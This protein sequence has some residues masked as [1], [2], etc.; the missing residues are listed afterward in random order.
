MAPYG[1]AII[2][3]IIGINEADGSSPQA[4]IKARKTTL[5]AVQKM[6]NP[7]APAIDQPNPR[8]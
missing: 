8:L 4:R 5:G 3:Y 7:K 2:V 1:H 6:K